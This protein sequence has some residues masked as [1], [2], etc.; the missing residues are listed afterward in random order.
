MKILDIGTKKTTQ[1]MKKEVFS[2]WTKANRTEL[3]ACTFCGSVVSICSS[4]VSNNRGVLITRWNILD[5][6]FCKHSVFHKKL[7][8]RSSTEFCTISDVWLGPEYASE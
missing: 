3:W 4:E 8:L 5:G 1:L 2:F 6:T 7:R